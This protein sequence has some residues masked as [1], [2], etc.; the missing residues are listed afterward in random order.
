MNTTTLILER[1]D[2]LRSLLKR[3]DQLE[4]EL[5]QLKF[6]IE[7]LSTERIPD[8]MDAAE[9][10][11][12]ETPYG[13][14][15]LKDDIDCSLPSELTV[16][17]MTD[18]EKKRASYKRLNDAFSYLKKS[19]GESIIQAT[20]ELNFSKGNLA[21]AEKVAAKVQ[22]YRPVVFRNVHN[23]TLK[24]FLKEQLA[25]GKNPPFDLFAITGYRE[26]VIKTKKDI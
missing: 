13:E 4:S 18:P 8:L 5:R 6:A 25:K 22:D 10:S 11:K 2:R 23:A 7:S 17:R 3:K 20:V 9:L 19:G 14:V 26:V 1:V 12:F 24:K 21:L 15:S 16:A